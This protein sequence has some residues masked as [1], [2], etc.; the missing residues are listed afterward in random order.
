M[1]GLNK[2]PALW[3]PVNGSSVCYV[4]FSTFTLEYFSRVLNISIPSWI[5]VQGVHVHYCVFS[6]LNYLSNKRYIQKNNFKNKLKQF[7]QFGMSF[8]SHC[9]HIVVHIA[10][11]N[12]IAG[13]GWGG[14]WKWLSPKV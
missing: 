4:M 7:Q 14:N 9:A 8:S 6:F 12:G 5:A 1:Q 13:G 2:S 10:V 3:F 11:L